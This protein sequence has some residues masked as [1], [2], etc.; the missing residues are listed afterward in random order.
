MKCAVYYFCILVWFLLSL[1][2]NITYSLFV[3]NLEQLTLL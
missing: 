2:L 3:I 1:S